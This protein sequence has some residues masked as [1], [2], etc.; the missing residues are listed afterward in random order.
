MPASP[1]SGLAALVG[2][3]GAVGGPPFRKSLV[4]AWDSVWYLRIA[5]HGYGTKIR[6][7]ST[8]AVRATVRSSP[9]ARD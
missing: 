1:P 2:A 8:G 6:V 7:T 4:H 9:S 5:V 3:V